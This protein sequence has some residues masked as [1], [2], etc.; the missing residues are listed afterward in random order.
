LQPAISELDDVSIIAL[1]FSRESYFVFPSST[2]MEVRPL[3]PEKADPPMLVTLL[4]IVTDLRPL[5]L[6]KV[7][8]SMLVTLLGI[9]TDLRP[10]QPSYLQNALYQQFAL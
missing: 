4:G 10:L 3:Q 6:E 8:Y 7:A 9:V 2:M 1:Q 5:Q